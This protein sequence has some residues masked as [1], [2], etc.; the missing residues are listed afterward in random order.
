[1]L[2]RSFFLSLAAVSLWGLAASAQGAVIIVDPDAGT[3]QGN[4]ISVGNVA[5]D[6]TRIDSP[7]ITLGVPIP[8][9]Y[10][11]SAGNFAN[12]TF[13][14][15]NSGFSISGIDN[16]RNDGGAAREDLR[17]AFMVTVPTQFTFSGEYTQTNVAQSSGRWFF[18]NSLVDHTDFSNIPIPTTSGTG[19][20][21]PGPNVLNLAVKTGELLPGHVYVWNTHIGS[22]RSATGNYTGSG[23]VSLVFAAAPEPGHLS[24]VMLGMTA[25]GL[26]WRRRK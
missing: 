7:S 21:A 9:T 23:E 16:A 14:F 1:M 22:L 13:T 24:L 15:S 6:Q 3:N 20:F 2:S 18:E 19:G 8:L 12:A 10:S 17:I 5:G 4:F 26:V 25:V 11:A